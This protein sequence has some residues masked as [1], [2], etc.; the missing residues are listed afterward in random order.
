MAQKVCQNMQILSSAEIREH[1]K[2]IG[3]SEKYED[4]SKVSMQLAKKKLF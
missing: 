3:N 1:K 2:H 4:A